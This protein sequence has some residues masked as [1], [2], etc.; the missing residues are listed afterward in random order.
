MSPEITVPLIGGAQELT[1]FWIEN[2]LHGAGYRDAKLAGFE[3]RPIG[4]GNVSDTVRVALTYRS[5][6]EAPASIVCKFRCS[7]AQA[8]AHG[9]GSGSYGREVNSYR[10]LSAAGCACSIPR[11]FWVDGHT[12]NV[13][14][15]MEDLSVGTRA[16]DQVTG[17]S[18][19]D[20]RSVI[21]ELAKLHRTFFPMA[22]RDAPDWAMTMAATADYWTQ[23]ILKGLPVVQE[24]AASRLGAA[25]MAIVEKAAEAAPAWYRLPVE[26]GTLTHGDPRVD[27]I[28]FRD[29]SGGP[30]AVIIDWQMTGW[31]SPMHDIGYFLSGSVSVEDRRS[32]EGDLLDMYA[33]IVGEAYPRS[34]IEADYRLQL[35]SGLMTTLAAYGVLPMTPQVD[36]LLMALLRRNIA[37]VADWRSLEALIP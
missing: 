13:N 18:V 11:L 2:V 5:T 25:G 7:D 14:L 35:P 32:A 3:A 24:T 9:V 31:R 1:A 8:H 20:A 10:A 34:L 36:A 12:E 27:N 4:A 15:V 28:I 26:R 17:C 29:G 21:A 19:D 16:G 6:T 23:A 22:Q 30:Q 33:A 37:A